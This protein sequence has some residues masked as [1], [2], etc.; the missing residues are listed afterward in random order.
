M[1]HKQIISLLV[2][3]HPGVLL[4]ITGLFTRRGFN[5]DSLTVSETQDAQYSR[6]TIV[7]KGD[8]SVANQVICQVMK[9][10]DV[11]KAVIVPETE[12]I[13][14]E[15]MLIKVNATPAERAAMYKIAAT[16]HATVVN[17]GQSS[18]TMQAT[19]LPAELD[20]MIA[21]LAKQGILE[22]VRTGLTAL[23]H[24]DTCITSSK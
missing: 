2:H 22:M 3:N 6:M 18:M 23:Q 10:A 9:V 5:I 7:V 11:K 16:Y 12:A 20:E 8:D 1:E 4:R 24:G 17:V 19:A 15:L 21:H 13:C 14:C